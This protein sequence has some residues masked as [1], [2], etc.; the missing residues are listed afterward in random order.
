MIE[1]SNIGITTL[2]LK[3]IMDMFPNLKFLTNEDILNNI[4]FLKNIGCDERQIKN[5]IL[6]NP[7]YLYRT[8]EDLTS[9]VNKLISLNILNINLL[10]ESNPYFLNKDAFEIDDYIKYRLSIGRKLI[11]IIDEI[12]DNPYIIDEIIS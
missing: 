10:F 6:S 7:S 12:I 4:N 2:E 11:D 5:I 3:E 9:L 1:L 8:I